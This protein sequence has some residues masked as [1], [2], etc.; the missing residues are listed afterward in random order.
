MSARLI[1]QG[2]FVLLTLTACAGKQVPLSN[3]S[4][5]PPESR[6]P[7]AGVEAPTSEKDLIAAVDLANSVFFPPSGTTVDAA[8]RQ[9]LIAHAARLKEN[10]ELMVTLV[11]HTDDLGSSSYNLAIAEQRVNAVYAI[12]RSQGV[13]L[14]QIQRYSIGSE[15]TGRG[16]KSA[17]CRRSMRRVQLMFSQ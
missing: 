6:K 11:G 2:V 14:T 4:A 8:G 5:P 7:E 16:C 10:P 1:Y 3:E 17:D 12:L 9:R 15:Q 13:P